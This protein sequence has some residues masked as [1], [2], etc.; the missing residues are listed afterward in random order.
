M[1]SS[2]VT[3]QWWFLL[4][5]GYWLVTVVSLGWWVARDASARGSD[6][7]IRWAV[8]AVATPVGLPYYLY[9]RFRRAGLGASGTHSQLDRLL[10][11]VASA[12]VGGLLAGAAFGPPDPFSQVRV[13]ATSAAVLLP[14]A[15]LFVSRQWHR[16]FNSA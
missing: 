10:G 15:Y 2:A 7:P 5:V 14:V 13:A 12:T 8:A 6:H 4:G 11:T 16:H 1:S 3:L 9:R